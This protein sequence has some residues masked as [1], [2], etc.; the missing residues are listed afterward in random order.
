[1]WVA[2]L[3]LMGLGLFFVLFSSGFETCIPFPKQLPLCLGK[4]RETLQRYQR[5]EVNPSH[6]Y[7][8]ASEKET[9]LARG[10]FLVAS[11]ELLDFNFSQTVVLLIEY[12]PNGAMG[13]IINRPTEVRLSEL[14]PDIEEL[15]YR[16]DNVFIGGPVARNQLLMLIRSD[17]EIDG[18]HLVF[19]DV[20]A[21]TSRAV[22][23]EMANQS[24]SDESFRV[25]AGYAGW[26]PGQLDQEF[27][28]G[29][30]HVLRADK[31]TVFEKEPAQIWA[32]LIRWFAGQWVDI[33]SSLFG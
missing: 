14:L 12:G 6:F 24:D 20:Y 33:R 3:S 7:S 26:A 15:A 10:K 1:M 32:E 27:S 30:W 11:R 19:E 23:E 17:R 18:A 28:R 8:C 5:P 21:S 2:V 29:D 31:E 13:L 25:Y 16:G 22:L 4:D 9:E